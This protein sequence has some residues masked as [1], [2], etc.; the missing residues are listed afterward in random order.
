[1]SGGQSSLSTVSLP[2]NGTISFVQLGAYG[3]QTLA[4]GATADGAIAYAHDFYRVSRGIVGLGRAASSSHGGDDAVID[5]GISRKLQ[6]EGWQIVPRAGLSYFHIGQASFAET[7]ASSLDLSVGPAALDALRSR[8]GVT[9]S[10]V[11]MLGETRLTPELRA[12]WTHDFLDD[13]DAFGATFAGAPTVSFD[14]I[15]APTGRDAAELGAGI[16]FAISQTTI[17]GQLSAFV[18]YDATIAAHQTDNA[19]AAGLKLTW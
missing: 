13:R 16:S 3:A 8:V 10:Q 14:Q 19:V 11:L 6:L 5:V 4:Y 18:Q 7:G 9:V 15:G 2:E 12:A 1:M 17:P